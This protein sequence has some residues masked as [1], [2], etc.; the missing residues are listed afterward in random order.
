MWPA[1]ARKPALM[2]A[3]TFDDACAKAT[4]RRSELGNAVVHDN[5]QNYDGRA[6]RF[7]D[8]AD[9]PANARIAA[10]LRV[11]LVRHMF[12]SL[13]RGCGAIR[14]G[15]V[16]LRVL[17]AGCGSGRDVA[18][19]AD[20]WTT[21]TVDGVR[22]G[23]RV[24]ARGFDCSRRLVDIARRRRLAVDQGDFESFVPDAH[25]ARLDGIFCLASLFHV[26][27]ARLPGVLRR[28]R[29]CLLPAASGDAGGLLLTS[30]PG[31]RDDDSRG[32]DGR[33]KN[34]MPAAMQ[35]QHLRDAGFEVLEVRQNV[36]PL[37]N[38]HWVVVIARARGL[39][40]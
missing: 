19:F 14:N 3:R 37:Y 12:S 7:A 27:R 10:E 18:G 20:D 30:L 21:C 4:P 35:E 40:P 1:L 8:W 34:A 23:L 22:H 31:G 33:W 29:E 39:L 28:L 6:Q 38:G 26:P 5:A 32:S 16:T 36:G 25:G 13:G 15:V 11:L 9:E 17:D 24:E 2:A